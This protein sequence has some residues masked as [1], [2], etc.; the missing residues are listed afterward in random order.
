MEK[1]WIPESLLRCEETPTLHC[2]VGPKWTVSAAQVDVTLI[3]SMSINNE[4]ALNTIL[5]I[6]SYDTIWSL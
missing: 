2:S 3:N 5:C 6:L 4:N 1:F